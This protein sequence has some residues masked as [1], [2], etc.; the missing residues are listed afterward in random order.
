MENTQL[1]QDFKE[2]LRLLN[3]NKIKYLLIG[4][5][6]VGYHGYPRATVDLDIWISIDE[7]NVN[8]IIKVIN[9]FGFRDPALS[10]DI[11]IKKKKMVRLGVPPIRLEILSKID[12]LNFEDS[13]SNKILDEIDGASVNIIDLES[14]KINKKASGPLK[15]LSDLEYLP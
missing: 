3:S 11:F 7:N 15:D 9:E 1:P 13:Y 2:F 8:K 10:S 6:A 5:Y 14:L 4:G 12:G